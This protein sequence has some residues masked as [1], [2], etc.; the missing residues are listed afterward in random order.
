MEVCTLKNDDEWIECSVI[1]VNGG[2]ECINDP[3]ENTSECNGHGVCKT[4]FR[5]LLFF[6]VLRLITRIPIL[7]VFNPNIFNSI[8]R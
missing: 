4:D 8:E 5:E 3:V 6:I 2:I 1:E 7:L